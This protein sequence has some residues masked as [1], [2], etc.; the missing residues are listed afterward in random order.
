MEPREAEGRKAVLTE[1]GV[2]GEIKPAALLLLVLATGCASFQSDL[3]EFVTPLCEEFGEQIIELSVF[4]AHSNQVVPRDPKAISGLY[5]K[6]TDRVA[7]AWRADGYKPLVY[8]AV[9][10]P[11]WTPAVQSRVSRFLKEQGVPI[12]FRQPF[13][14]SSLVRGDFF[15]EGPKG[16]QP[17]SENRNY[18]VFVIGP[19]RKAGDSYVVP[20]GAL[21]PFY[22]SIPY[23]FFGLG[24]EYADLVALA[25]GTVTV[26]DPQ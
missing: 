2:R 3:E 5:S 17:S 1:R 24:D 18:C 14:E 8:H 6:F 10:F 11:G 7:K 26:R 23:G 19:A 12:S 9:Q 20:V 21:I 22:A 4:D 25:T 16:L 15:D 13:L